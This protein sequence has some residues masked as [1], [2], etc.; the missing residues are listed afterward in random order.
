ML[1]Q[2]RGR[3]YLTLRPNLRRSWARSRASR[4]SDRG[5]GVEWCLSRA[6][7]NANVSRESRA[8]G[9]GLLTSINGWWNHDGNFS[10]AEQLF[11]GLHNGQIDLA[12]DCSIRD[13]VNVFWTIVAV[14]LVSLVSALV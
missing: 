1:E 6:S 7:L 8:L 4:Q 12:M 11:L 5:R 14:D 3:G 2:G 9:L 10:F 13:R